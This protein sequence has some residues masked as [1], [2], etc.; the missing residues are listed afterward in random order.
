MALTT[1]KV[2]R[3]SFMTA[4]GKTFS[5]SIPYPK[6]DLQPADALAAMHALIDDDLFLTAGGA[7][8]GVKDIKVV[9]T[10][11]EDLYDPLQP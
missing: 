2:L 4:G 7:L 5:I 10:S 8:T 9:D 11:T 1:N 3:L 6:E